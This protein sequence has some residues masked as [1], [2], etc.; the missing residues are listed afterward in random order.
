MFQPK[1]MNSMPG[2]PGGQQPGARPLM[3]RIM[4]L[5]GNATLSPADVPL[6][7]Y[8]ELDQRQ[9]DFFSFLDGELEK[10]ESFY[11]QK[12]DE[13]TERLHIMREQLHFM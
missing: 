1:R 6:P 13:A 2:N 4:S 7:A 12:E 10:I 8:R 11:K 5:G 9:D 3:K